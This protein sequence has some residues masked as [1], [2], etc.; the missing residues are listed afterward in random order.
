MFFDILRAIGGLGLFLLGLNLLVE[1]LKGVAGPALRAGL[2]RFTNSPLSGAVTGAAATALMQSSSVVTV[3]AV[4]FVSA[5]LI[6]F[7]QALGIIFGANVG[8]TATGWIVSL[9]GFKLDLSVALAPAAFVGVMLKVF[10]V[11]KV[12]RAGWAIA[13]FGLMFT[14]LSVMQ[15]VMAAFADHVSPANFPPDTIIGR[16]QMVGIGVAMA[17]VMQSSSAGV[18]TALVALSA[19]AISFPQAA[20][21]VIGLDIGT[22]ITALLATI[23]GSAAT[24]R[25]GL[26]HL[27]FNLLTAILAF[28]ILPAWVALVS[29]WAELADARQAHFALVG[30]HTTFNFIGA[31]IGIALAGPFARLL[32]A[33][34]PEEEPMGARR[35]DKQLLSEP[36]AAIEPL[37]AAVSDLARQTLQA[38]E[39][40]LDPARDPPMPEAFDAIA[41][42]RDGMERALALVR[43]SPDQEGLH[44]RHVAILHALDHAGRL[45]QRL[46]NVEI[47]SLLRNDD[48]LTSIARALAQ[49]AGRAALASA[50]RAP[51][52]AMEEDAEA[53]FTRLDQDYRALRQRMLAQASQGQTD[54][55]KALDRLDGLRFSARIAYH[56]WRIVHH[57]DRAGAF[58]RA[59][60]TRPL[61]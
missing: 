12:G 13:G 11:G 55:V 34:V 37:T 43:T 8:T 30:F 7:P 9:I 40:A 49:Q 53:L 60:K 14:G 58:A 4:G 61:Q 32:T 22:T 50:K 3:M 10:G 36:Q 52:A 1:G 2:A 17:I 59:D 41:Q 56:I 5:S 57:L 6:T 27:V 16:L 33:L 48:E 44:Q 47:L 18:A 29:M 15:S 24:R 39:D 26:A 35:F 19:G 23:G 21:L 54:V 45:Q 51:V 46:R 38:L 28:V 20:A 42:E 31:M 25:T